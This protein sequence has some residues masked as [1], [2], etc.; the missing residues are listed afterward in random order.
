MPRAGPITSVLTY[1]TYIQNKVDLLVGLR[2]Y[3]Y[4]D[5]P[6][7]LILFADK[8]CKINILIKIF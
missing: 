8:R 3:H 1:V 5:F 6:T 4:D 2:Y 7:S